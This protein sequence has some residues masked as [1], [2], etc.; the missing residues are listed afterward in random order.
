MILFYKG[1]K[2]KFKITDKN[3][4][5]IIAMIVISFMSSYFLTAHCYSTLYAVVDSSDSRNELV[6]LFYDHDIRTMPWS[7]LSLNQT[8]YYVKRRD[9]SLIR[10]LSEKEG[11]DTSNYVYYCFSDNDK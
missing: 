5:L 1:D 2:L 6:N 9:L 7:I 8:Y 3:R 10:Y 4:F 11:I